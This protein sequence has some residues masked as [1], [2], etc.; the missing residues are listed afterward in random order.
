MTGPVL[1][2]AGRAPVVTLSAGTLAQLFE[3]SHRLPTTRLWA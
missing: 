3:L 2:R 1:F